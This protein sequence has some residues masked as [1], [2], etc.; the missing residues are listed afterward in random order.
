MFV[1]L[2]WTRIYIV[3]RSAEHSTHSWTQNLLV[4]VTKSTAAR[5][6]TATELW[7][8]RNWTVVYTQYRCC[9]WMLLNAEE[10]CTWYLVYLVCNVL[11]NRPRR[12]INDDAHMKHTRTRKHHSWLPRHEDLDV[13]PLSSTAA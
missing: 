3:V 4:A 5:S 6:A 1:S 13:L 7:Y 2:L 8:R 12:K 10:K 9:M 11:C